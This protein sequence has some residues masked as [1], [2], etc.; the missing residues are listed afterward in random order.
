RCLHVAALAELSAASCNAGPGAKAPGPLLEAASRDGEAAMSFDVDEPQDRC[1]LR[2]TH[3]ASRLQI[4]PAIVTKYDSSS[5][6]G[7]R[8]RPVSPDEQAVSAAARTST[9]CCCAVLHLH[10]DHACLFGH[11]DNP[12]DAVRISRLFSSASGHF[13]VRSGFRSRY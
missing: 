13:P 2:S 3:P 11:A 6:N 9:A 7:A 5:R 4:V 12:A 1:R 8:T 10:R